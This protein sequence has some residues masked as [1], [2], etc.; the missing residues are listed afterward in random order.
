MVGGSIYLKVFDHSIP[1]FVPG[2]ILSFFWNKKIITFLVNTAQHN[3]KCNSFIDELF[4]NSLI[5]QPQQ[6]KLPNKM[7]VMHITVSI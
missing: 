1:H 5:D 7:S 4:F 6:N 2:S 3:V